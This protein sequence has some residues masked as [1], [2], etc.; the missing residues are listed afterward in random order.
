[1][2]DGPPRTL[3][4]GKEKLTGEQIK[5]SSVWKDSIYSLKGLRVQ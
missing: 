1:M 2:S 5:Q 3:L 4:H